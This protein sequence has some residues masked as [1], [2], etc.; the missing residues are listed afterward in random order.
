[1]NDEEGSIGHIWRGF[2][3]SVII[4]PIHEIRKVKRVALGQSHSLILTEDGEVYGVGSNTHGQL[5]IGHASGQGFDEP[6][7][8]EALQ[9]KFVKDVACGPRHSGA[10]LG[11]GEVYMWGNNENGQCG[12]DEK[13]VSVPQRVVFERCQ[14]DC[15]HGK[16]RWTDVIVI[17]Y[18]S[19]GDLHT[20]A[21][22]DK[23][24]IWIW[25]SGTALGL[26]NVGQTNGPNRLDFFHGKKALSVVC[27]GNHTLAI[28]SSNVIETPADNDVSSDLLCPWCNVE[29]FSRSFG[30][31]D[32]SP[33]CPL[34]LPIQ[35]PPSSQTEKLF[36]LEEE[37]LKDLKNER[38]SQNLT[39]D[40]GV[41]SHS[42]NESVE[43]QNVDLSPSGLPAAGKDGESL[44]TKSVASADE[45]NESAKIPVSAALKAK[46]L[47]SMSESG[48]GTKILA[49]AKSI[50]I[51]T[52]EVVKLR[53]R[54]ESIAEGCEIN[55]DECVAVEENK[56]DAK[57]NSDGTTPELRPKSGSLIDAQ[58]A[59]EYLAQRLS[60]IASAMSPSALTNS[61]EPV[62]VYEATTEALRQNV[63]TL[64]NMVMSGVV[65][66]VK[67]TVDRF[68]FVSRHLSKDYDVHSASSSL[69]GDEN[70]E[71]EII[72]SDLVYMTYSPQLTKKMSFSARAQSL[73]TELKRKMS[74]SSRVGRL[75]LIHI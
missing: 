65:S 29:M 40:G 69:D 41:L 26:I 61:K 63:G 7:K 71:F 15:V 6:I 18:I 3:K 11:T 38:L 35:S 21:L 28:I 20:A 64:T 39:E 56:Q 68:G 10:I 52:S 34:G 36:Q 47:R 4:T 19:C 53:S 2:G 16:K 75:S 59:K 44:D 74:R 31:C 30:N 51:A 66:G 60:G 67:N 45:S 12:I 1:M 55:A 58:S 48:V 9:E 33:I 72:D 37:F 5:G 8:I 13:Q 43:F 22:S 42:R 17:T 73:K 24:E 70:G 54:S 62:F 27:G 25:G 50:E 49:T 14:E 57:D 23:N 32:D 46:I